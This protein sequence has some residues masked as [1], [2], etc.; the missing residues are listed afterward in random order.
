[1]Y[2]NVPVGGS[3]G[4]YEVLDEIGR[5]AKGVV[6]RARD[7]LIGRVVAIKVVNQS[8]LESVGVKA[9]EYFQRFTREAEVAGRLNHPAIVK[10]YDLGLNYLVMEFV[11][12]RSLAAMMST[13]AGRPLSSALDIVGQVAAALDHAHT[14]GIVHRDIKP[15]NIMVRPDGTVKVMD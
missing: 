12:G 8:Y 10:I 1:M 11:E 5:G 9:E 4:R 2:H 3:F 15:A 14:N 7:P 13:L 6:Y